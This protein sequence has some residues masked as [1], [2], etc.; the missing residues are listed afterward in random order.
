MDAVAIVVTTGSGRVPVPAAS[1]GWHRPLQTRDLR[2]H[3][4][5]TARTPDAG[6]VSTHTG[7]FPAPV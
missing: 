1:Q 4:Q 3:R 6:M 7:S 2:Q 5:H